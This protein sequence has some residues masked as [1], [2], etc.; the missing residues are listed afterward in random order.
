MR[1]KR[2]F[3]GRAN[4]AANGSNRQAKRRLAGDEVSDARAD[5]NRHRR[6]LTTL[7]ANV[8]VDR[9]FS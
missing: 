2:P 8:V 5:H 4:G 7:I 9:L 3:P 1:T 6:Q